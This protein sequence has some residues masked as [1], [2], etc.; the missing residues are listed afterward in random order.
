M[1]NKILDLFKKKEVKLDLEKVYE[2]HKHTLE[3]LMV[4]D[5]IGQI[6][7]EINEPALKIFESQ[8]EMFEKW[9]LWQSYYVN[10]KV[11]N[12]PVKIGFYNGMM[13]YLKVLHTIARVNKKDYTAPKKVESKEVEIPWIDK[14]LQGISEFKN[15]LQNNKTN[16]T[17]TEGTED[18]KV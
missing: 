6:P 13:V 16:S 12:D 7:K 10:R 5:F 17:K 4:K 11:I 3:L 15:D 18:T 14:A 2:E 1:K 8:A 9:I